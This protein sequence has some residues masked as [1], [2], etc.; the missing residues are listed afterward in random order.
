[1][2]L[3]NKVKRKLTSIIKLHLTKVHESLILSNASKHLDA[4]NDLISP[5]FMIG[6]PGSLHIMAL[7]AKYIP[8]D[9]NLVLIS[10]GMDE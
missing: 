9:V 5:F 3:I 7:A 10:N 2:L 4:I 1:M 8:S 6:I